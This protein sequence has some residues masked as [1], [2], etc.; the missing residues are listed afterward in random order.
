MFIVP[1]VT[2]HSINAYRSQVLDTAVVDQLIARGAKIKER[3]AGRKLWMVNSTATGGGVAE[4]MP[5]LC[6][7][8]RELGVD[9]DWAV[10]E[11][12]DPVFFGLTKKLHNY[13]H[14]FTPHDG[15]PHISDDEM[16]CYRQ[17]STENM[18]ALLREVGENDIVVIHDPQ[19]A[20]TGWLLKEARPS[21]RMHWRCHIGVDFD[22]SATD[23][24]WSFLENWLKPYERYI[25]TAQEYVPTYCSERAFLLPPAIDPLSDKNE[26]MTTDAATQYIQSVGVKVVTTDGSMQSVDSVPLSK[27]PLCLQISRWDKLKGWVELLQG[28]AHMKQ[29]LAAG[30]FAQCSEEQQQSLRDAYLVLGG[31]DPSGVSD[32]PEGMETL[33]EVMDV[34]ASLSADIQDSVCIALLPLDHKLVSALQS[35]SDIVIQNSLQEGFGLTVTE[36]MWKGLPVIGTNAVGIKLQ[37]ND[38]DNGLRISNASDPQAISTSI[39]WM[40][41]NSDTRAAMGT[42]AKRSVA[43]NFLITRQISDY[44][45]I[46]EES[47]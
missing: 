41:T 46:V 23:A 42:E 9:V 40:L 15:A 28:F 24:A 34:Y 16:A 37:I 20:G 6:Y 5:T 38:H 26:P 32:D 33:Q 13:I 43:E 31:P 17:V 2:C 7:L 1:R 14:G 30:G 22:N 25:F 45:D 18:R 27:R 8:L 35:V 21:I 4:M 44:F 12:D 3:L 47:L 10:I 39:A 29:E 11:S 19:P 36:A